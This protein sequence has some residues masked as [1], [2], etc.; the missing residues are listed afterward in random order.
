MRVSFLLD[1][2][3]FLLLVATL[4]AGR[5]PG[6]RTLARAAARG[7]ARGRAAGPGA[8]SHAIAAPAVRR[9]AP[10][11]GRLV[12][13]AIASRPPPHGLMDTNDSDTTINSPQGNQEHHEAHRP[14]HRRLPASWRSRPPPRPTS[15]SSRRPPPR[16]P[17]PSRPSASRTRPTTRS[18]TRSPSSSRRA[19]PR[20]ATSRSR[21]GPSRSPRRSSRRRSGPTTARSPRASRRSPGRRAPRRPASSPGSSR[22]SRCSVQIPGKAGDTL[23]F[24]ALQYYSDGSVARW[25]GA[26]DADKPAPQVQVTAAAAT[27]RDE[28]HVG[29]RRHRDDREHLGA[30][31][32]TSSSLRRLLGL[33]QH[34]G[35]HRADRRRARPGGRRRGPRRVTAQRLIRT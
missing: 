24:K 33:L 28:R 1:C 10:R 9:P 13:S 8:P 25:I 19:S 20:S 27:H 23:T 34:A 15:P 30:D 26:P 22:T 35:D 31:A 4:L 16:G 5:Y 17:T 21:A 2:L 11:G 32:A 29:R 14:R 7:T 6:E 18:P 3:P 12:G